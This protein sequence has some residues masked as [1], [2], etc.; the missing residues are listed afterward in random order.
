M[1]ATLE[2]P[3]D[4][5]TDSKAVKVCH[6]LSYL[7]IGFLCSA[8]CVLAENAIDGIFHKLGDDWI[9][10]RDVQSNGFCNFPVK[11]NI[12]NSSFISD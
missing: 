3:P 10:V 1:T 7:S 8:E 6:K 5:V 2:C 12:S 11:G 4:L 9:I